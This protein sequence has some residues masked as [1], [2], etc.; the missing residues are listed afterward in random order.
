MHML[1]V[2]SSYELMTGL[3]AIFWI[4]LFVHE[5][6]LRAEML[7]LGLLGIFLL[8]VSFGVL[9]SENIS[10]GFFH[11][12]LADLLFT[13]IVA[14]LAAVLFHAFLGKHYHLLPQKKHPP[15]EGLAQW[16]FVYLLFALL[17][18]VWTTLLMAMAF[19]FSLAVSVL[20]GAAMLTIYLV[21]HRHDLLYDALASAALTGFVVFLAAE[22]AA[23]FTSQPVSISL[24]ESSG[25]IGS[26][27]SDL[28]LWSIGIGLLLG[29]LYEYIR[30]I[31]LK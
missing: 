12:Q 9:A 1:S 27:P 18:F 26:V 20:L 30:R 3:L 22:L 13:F 11:L 16:W 5:K 23:F 14:S 24:I 29:P 19:N 7:T 21:S 2:L 15:K 6:E 17:F 25:S 8:P 28:I 31:Q 4:A 10:Y